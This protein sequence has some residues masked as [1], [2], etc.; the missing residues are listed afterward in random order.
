M[1]RLRHVKLLLQTVM[2]KRS[3]FGDIAV[4]GME[5][6]HFYTRLKDRDHP[7]PTGMRAGVEYVMPTRR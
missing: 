6:A 7:W 5:G 4:H 2:S 1:V 3:L